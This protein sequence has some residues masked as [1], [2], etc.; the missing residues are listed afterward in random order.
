M[1]NTLV[2]FALSSVPQRKKFYNNHSRCQFKKVFALILMIGA[3]KLE[4]LFFIVFLASLLLFNG[5]TESA[6]N[7]TMQVVII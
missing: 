1:K 7:I 5:K 3:R 4:C 2:Y 6:V